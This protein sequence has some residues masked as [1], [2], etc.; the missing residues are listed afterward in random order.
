[1]KEV[2]FFMPWT[3]RH[4]RDQLWEV[5]QTIQEE[6]A[7]LHMTRSEKRISFERKVQQL[8]QEE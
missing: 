3:A 6:L 5:H 7:Q 1:M 4:E 8:E 2:V